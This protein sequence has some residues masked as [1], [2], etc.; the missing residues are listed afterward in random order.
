[1]LIGFVYPAI[2]NGLSLA[3]GPHSISGG[4]LVTAI[5]CEGIGDLCMRYSILKSAL[6]APIIR[7]RKI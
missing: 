6:Y 1:V 4:V 5:M 3:L 7:V 2:V